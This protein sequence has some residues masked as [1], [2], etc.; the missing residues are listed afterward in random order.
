M[1]DNEKLI[2]VL[3]K[4]NNRLSEVNKSEKSACQQQITSNLNTN[5]LKYEPIKTNKREKDN[6]CEIIPESRREEE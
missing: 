2:N 3:I 1:H 5:T 6:A 4:L